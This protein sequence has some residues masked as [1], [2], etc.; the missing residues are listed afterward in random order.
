MLDRHVIE[1]PE[2]RLRDAIPDLIVRD[3]VEE[4][5]DLRDVAVNLSPGVSLADAIFASM[6][7]HRGRDFRISDEALSHEAATS[8]LVAIDAGPKSEG[9][10]PR[11][12]IGEPPRDPRH[13]EQPP[14][15]GKD[16]DGD[17]H[18]SKFRRAR[19]TVKTP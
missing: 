13:N 1:E 6:L 2:Q 17:V 7:T 19:S 16:H 10:T 9:G 3:D 11:Q 18:R 14:E 12:S 8:Q 4:R 15:E 5:D